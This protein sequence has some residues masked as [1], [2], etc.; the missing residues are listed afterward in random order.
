MNAQETYALDYERRFG[1]VARL[2]GAQGAKRLQDSHVTVVGLGGVGSWVAEALVR[3]AV[4]TLTLIDL[5]NVAESNT[6]RQIMAMT[7]EYGKPKVQALKERF[8]LINPTCSI[9]L[10]EDFIDEENV[11]ELVPD[12]SVII[13][14]I[15]QVKAKCALAAYAR[16]KK[17]KII[18]CGAAG[19]KVNPQNIL[20][21]DLAR[22]K[23]DPLLSSMRHDLRKKYGFPKAKEKG[24]PEKFGISAVYSEEQVK[25]PE[26]VC[27]A[28]LSSGLACSGYGSGVVETAT[29]GFI[30]ASVAINAIVQKK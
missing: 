1:G 2:Y 30:A 28:E 3:T 5:D 20:I 27:P 16:S 9:N 22:A 10:V 24:Q 21:E 15:D 26:G 7:G 18:T 17:I 19:G 14:C 25:R 11:S 4:G 8:L 12:C 13:D 29:L 23:G 6:N